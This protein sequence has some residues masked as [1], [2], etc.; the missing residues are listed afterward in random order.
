MLSY[1][2]CKYNLDHTKDLLSL[3]HTHTYIYIY[4]EKFHKNILTKFR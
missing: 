2:S 3:S 4:M 1:I